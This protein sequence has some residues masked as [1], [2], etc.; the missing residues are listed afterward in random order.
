MLLIGRTVAVASF[1]PIFVIYAG[2]PMTAWLI[3]C[4]LL[5]RLGEIRDIPEIIHD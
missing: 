1:T 2:L 4:F 5:P 3:V